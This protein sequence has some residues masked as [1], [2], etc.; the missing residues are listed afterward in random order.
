MNFPLLT[1]EK[2]SIFNSGM[3]F[4]P[5]RCM[6]RTILVVEDDRLNR[7]LISKVLRQEGYQVLEACD[8]AIALEMLQASPCNLVLTDFAMPKV[9]GSRFVEQ[10][11]ALQPQMPIILI[12]AYQSAV[13]GTTIVDKVAEVLAKPFD[14]TVL[15]SAVRRVLATNPHSSP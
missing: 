11:H 14:L 15:R 5:C 8:G 12:T 9:N 1:L 7:E 3:M 4:A 13:S 10:L 6:A 2:A